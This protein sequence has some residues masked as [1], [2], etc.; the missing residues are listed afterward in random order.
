MNQNSTSLNIILLPDQATKKIAIELSNVLNKKVKT[1][2]VL[3]GKDLIPHLTIYQAEFPNENKEKVLNEIEDMVKNIQPF[4]TNMGG[5][6]STPEGNIWW[7]SMFIE[8]MATLQKEVIKRCNTL[9]ENL[10][11][12]GLENLKNKDEDYKTEI[13]EYGSLW[14]FGRYVPHISLTAVEPELIKE[15]L[16]NLNF[17]KK[18]SFVSEKIAI[19]ALGNYGT[20]TSII[21]EFPI[22]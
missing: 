21:K 18:I 9:R 4:T 5:F 15:T 19:G 16:K 3:N 7:N 11:L 22:N 2:F 12:P 10:V 13:E 14:L 17:E 6:S 1:N 8:P 20:V